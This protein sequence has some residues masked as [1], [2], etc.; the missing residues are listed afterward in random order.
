MPCIRSRR[1]SACSHTYDIMEWNT[2]KHAGIT[3]T[4]ET[5]VEPAVCPQCSSGEYVGIVTAGTG[6]E[7]GGDHG[8]GKIYPY[9][10]RGLGMHIR[11][12]KHRREVCKKRGLI[13]VDGDHDFARRTEQ[14]RQDDAEFEEYMSHQRRL[15]DDPQY[16]EYRELRDKGF[17]REQFR[18]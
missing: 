4:M 12:A 17:Y 15:E 9:Y 7:Q 8:H 3:M 18:R 14:D 16:A 11:S 13:P 10:D 2:G 1:C 5:E 6:I